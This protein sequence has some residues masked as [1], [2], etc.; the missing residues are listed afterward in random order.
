MQEEDGQNQVRA[1][2]L[3]DL[4]EQILRKRS[5]LSEGRLQKASSRRRLVTDKLLKRRVK[6]QGGI[7]ALS[8][9]GNC[10]PCWQ[11]TARIPNLDINQRFFLWFQRLAGL[12]LFFKLIYQNISLKVGKAIAY[13]LRNKSL[14]CVCR[15]NGLIQKDRPLHGENKLFGNAAIIHR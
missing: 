7:L 6:S 2:L 10:L 9:L 3:G 5:S 4:K 14:C 1:L 15:N 13:T 8:L 12:F 11:F